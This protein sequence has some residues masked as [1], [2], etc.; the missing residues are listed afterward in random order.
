M[1]DSTM[2]RI[3]PPVGG[4]RMRKDDGSPNRAVFAPAEHPPA[5]RS[6][7]AGMPAE[8][9]TD[10]SDGGALLRWGDRGTRCRGA[11]PVGSTV[12]FSRLS[13]V[14]E[15][16]LRA[17]V[18]RGLLKVEQSARLGPRRLLR[19]AGSHQRSRGLRPSERLLVSA[20]DPR[21]HHLLA[22]QGDLTDCRR[23]G[24]PVRSRAHS[25]Q[26]KIRPT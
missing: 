11:L 17:K 1:A 15:P 24:H 20:P 18:R 19:P 26:S 16:Q 13:T 7:A 2:I 25:T 12:Y 9:T 8:A 14:S 21:L 22:G 10:Q 4:F 5:A 6:V 3:L 23:A